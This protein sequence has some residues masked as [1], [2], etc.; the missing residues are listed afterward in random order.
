MKKIIVVSIFLLSIL[1]LPILAQPFVTGETTNKVFSEDFSDP[2]K[3]FPITNSKDSK[4]W[5]AYGDGYYFMKRKIEQPRVILANFKGT[6]KDFYLK[7]K[8]QLGP[9]KSKKSTIGVLFLTQPNGKGGFLLEI[10][11][12]KQFRIKD[13]GN[14]ST[15]TTQGKEGWMASKYIFGVKQNN[16][17]EI[18]AFRGKFDIYINSQYIYSF[19]NKRYQKGAFGAYIGG[20]SE[21]K[22]IYFNIYTLE[23]PG[24]PEEINTDNLIEKMASLKAENDS[25]K[26]KVITAK[27]SNESN[28]DAI[29]AIKVLEDQVTASREENLYL[30][31]LLKD[32]EEMDPNTKAED[33]ESKSREIA[34]KII[35]ISIERDSLNDRCKLLE[36]KVKVME[37]KV[38]KNFEYLEK[39]KKEEEKEEKDRN[40]KV[41][42]IEKENLEKLQA[43]LELEEKK[44]NKDK[45][46]KIEREDLEK[47]QNKEKEEK[48]FKEEVKQPNKPSVGIDESSILGES[49]KKTE[50]KVE[51]KENKS[52]VLLPL[53]QQK[54]PVKKAVKGEFKDL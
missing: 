1:H 23:V 3:S 9:V 51:T 42:K 22:I 36:K 45:V 30:K 40:E 18:K 52:P 8:I 49:Y 19:I 20:F 13:I 26:L 25:L 6:S 48:K 29:F 10:N 33:S 24:A 53:I 50:E 39:Q 34:Q 17:V 12:K 4:F 14:N 11:K 15:I 43:Q 47:K 44:A 31:K 41:E 5:G 2:S 54:I 16:K 7:T 35:S 46:E 32:Y 38:T 37:I 27:Y 28:Q 21:A